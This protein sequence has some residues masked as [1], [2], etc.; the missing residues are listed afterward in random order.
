M[1]RSRDAAQ[2]CQT[3]FTGPW[4]SRRRAT[5][6]GC[7]MRRKEVSW[8]SKIYKGPY[9]PDR[10][11]ANPT[12]PTR[13][14]APAA[15]TPRAP[16]WDLGDVVFALMTW[17][18]RR[19]PTPRHK[20]T[21]RTTLTRRPRD[22][23]VSYTI[24]TYRTELWGEGTHPA[25]LNARTRGDMRHTPPMRAWLE[26]PHGRRHKAPPQPCVLTTSREPERTALKDFKRCN[27]LE[28]CG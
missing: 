1:A 28:A 13:A 9:T 4:A 15:Q 2:V 18:D 7:A 11:T 16:P 27:A 3:T 12:T 8:S 19:L 24:D 14:A 17:W 23:L 25:R 6:E 21:S 22:P 5:G 20:F 26:Q 10:P